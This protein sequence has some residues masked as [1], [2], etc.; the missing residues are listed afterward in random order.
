MKSILILSHQGFSF[1]EDLLTVVRELGFTPCV[2]ASIPPNQTRRAA[3]ENLGVAVA[4]VN[5][6]SLKLSDV[7]EAKAN[8]ERD[9]IKFVACISVWEGYRAIMAEINA[10]V[11]APDLDAATVFGLLD[12]FSMR[13]KLLDVG[14]TACHSKVVTKE[15]F[16]GL[17]S[18]GPKFIK[19][20]FGLA[21]FGA[22]IL[23]NHSF[24][25]LEN[26]SKEM[27]SDKEYDGIFGLNPEFLAEDLLDG[28]EVSFEVLMVGGKVKILGIHEKTDVEEAGQS[29]LEAACISPPISLT[30][31]DLKEGQIFI[32]KVFFVLNLKHGCFHV[33]AKLS[34]RGWEIIEIN[35]RIGGALIKESL[36]ILSGGICPLKLWVRSL[37][38]ETDVEGLAT[39]VDKKIVNA[40]TF[41]RVYFGKS[42]GIIKTLSESSQGRKPD[43]LKIAVKAG[44]VLPESSREIFL[45]QAL[46]RLD[47]IHLKEE[48]ASVRELSKKTLEV[49]YENA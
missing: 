1:L 18:S 47:P 4:W 39:E 32:R 30:D 25:D 41:F 33:E 11:G 12:K 36:K 9:G 26:L 42:G 6:H 31:N 20:R 14:L 16:D 19:P 44:A 27:K 49:E 3:V 22:F 45:A 5:T 17:K 28:T 46:W 29:T 37:L 43:L 38:A 15:N 24:L 7:T 35:P 48:F 8:F 10:A 13:Q 34:P 21:S 23:A 40:A 2:V